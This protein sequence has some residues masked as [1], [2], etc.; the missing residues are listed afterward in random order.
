MLSLWVV[1]EIGISTLLVLFCLISLSRNSFFN[2][3]SVVSKVA[4]KSYS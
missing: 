3:I 1:Q 2:Y 4:A